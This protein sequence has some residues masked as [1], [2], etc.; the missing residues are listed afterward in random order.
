MKRFL[1]LALLVILLSACGGA[2]SQ[3][4]P[5]PQIN[6]NSAPSVEG[7]VTAYLAAWNSGDY[8]AMYAMLSNESRNAITLEDFQAR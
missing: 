7:A 4:L 6:T 3:E 1:S 2:G 5:T 8:E